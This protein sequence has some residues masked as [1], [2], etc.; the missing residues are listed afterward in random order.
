MTLRIGYLLIMYFFAFVAEGGK[1]DFESVANS[2]NSLSQKFDQRLANYNYNALDYPSLAW[3]ELTNKAEFFVRLKSINNQYFCV[4][5]KH[6]SQ[7]FTVTIDKSDTMPYELDF[8]GDGFLIKGRVDKDGVLTID[9]LSAKRTG[10]VVESEFG[11]ILGADLVYD[12]P[13]SLCYMKAPYLINKGFFSAGEQIYFD[14]HTF[15]NNKKAFWGA[16]KIKFGLDVHTVINKGHIKAS[17]NV[18]VRAFRFYNMGMALIEA[19]LILVPLFYTKNDLIVGKIL[20]T[21][22]GDPIKAASYFWNNGCMQAKIVHVISNYIVNQGMIVCEGHKGAFDFDKDKNESVSLLGHKIFTGYVKA[23]QYVGIE[24]RR[25]YLTGPLH[26]D[27]GISVLA[28][29]S[30]GQ[31]F[32]QSKTI[33]AKDYVEIDVEGHYLQKSPIT[34]EGDENTFLKVSGMALL[35]QDIRSPQADIELQI[36]G[37]LRQLAHIKGKSV[38]IKVGE[39]YWNLGDIDSLKG[40]TRICAQGCWGNKGSIVSAGPIECWGGASI[41]LGNSHIDTNMWPEYLE[42]DPT[43]DSCIESANSSIVFKSPGDIISRDMNILADNFG[44]EW[45]AD[46]RIYFDGSFVPCD[47]CFVETAFKGWADSQIKK[48]PLYEH[49]LCCSQGGGFKY[50]ATAISDRKD[51]LDSDLSFDDAKR[52]HL[53]NLACSKNNANIAHLKGQNICFHAGGDISRNAF[54]DTHSTKADIHLLSEAGDI[55]LNG[56]S[57]STEDTNIHAKKGGINHYGNTYA[58][59]DMTIEAYGSIFNGPLYYRFSRRFP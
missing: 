50:L 48:Q 27:G 36:G 54:T 59:R 1:S 8:C 38:D 32:V 15:K 55:H 47:E 49:K 19:P 52:I 4:N 7:N 51:F 33:E 2:E 56:S 44:I 16:Q 41:L 14:G 23:A 26:S 40:H 25:V 6:K 21:D 45:Q 3:S 29:C 5:G 42:A 28:E 43:Y 39:S 46:G 53:G 30:P 57:K 9:A 37:E 17:E 18:T 12:E 22:D 35:R 58:G 34:N 10:F 31:T 20:S 13:E 24:G 11:V